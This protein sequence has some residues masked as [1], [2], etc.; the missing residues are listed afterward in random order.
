M[1][2]HIITSTVFDFEMFK[3]RAKEDRGPRHTV[4]QIAE[5]L[6]ATIHQ[7]EDNDILLVDRWSALWF[8][9]PEHWRIARI[10]TKSLSEDDTVFCAGQDVGVPFAFYKKFR[11]L[12][13]SLAMSSMAPSSHRFRSIFKFFGLSRKTDLYVVNDQ[14]KSSILQSN[15]AVPESK[16]FIVPEQT[17]ARFFTPAPG[18]I[19]KPRAM[20]ASAGMEQRDYATLAKAIDGLDLDVRI[21]AFSPNASKGQKVAMPEKVPE[22]MEIRYYEFTELR[23][24]YRSADVVA[25]SLLKN[26]YSAGLTVLMEAM[27]CARPVVITQNTGLPDHLTGEGVVVGVKPSDH[28]ALRD[29]ITK[30]LADKDQAE[31]LA[32]ESHQYFQKHHTS[33][34]YVENLSAA[35]RALH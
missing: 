23:D 26:D 13:F 3:R 18:L 8:G 32:E 11:R 34:V 2:F 4:L 27:A 19:K 1:S 12:K 20:I 17:D 30:L 5:N 15:F 24:L 29:A 28:V 22:N 16:I 14:Y 10:V 9:S 31:T 21:C 6:D 35:L 7:P 33:E 25:V